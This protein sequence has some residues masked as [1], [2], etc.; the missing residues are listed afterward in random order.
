MLFRSEY[1]SNGAI[2]NLIKEAKLKDGFP[3]RGKNEGPQ[4]Y[5]TRCRQWYRRNEP[6]YDKNLRQ[7]MSKGHIKRART[8]GP[9]RYEKTK[10]TEVVQVT[11]KKTLMQRIKEAIYSIFS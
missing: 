9:A 6:N 8:H 10:P 7:N 4:E 11:K 3:V 2:G 1:Y 5:A